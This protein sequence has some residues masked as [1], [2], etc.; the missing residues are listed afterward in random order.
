MDCRDCQSKIDQ[1]LTGMLSPDD[2][3]TF[4]EHINGCQNCREKVN[5]NKYVNDLIK[6]CDVT[7]PPIDVTKAVMDKITVLNL[8]RNREF[9][10]KRL[11]LSCRIS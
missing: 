4:N 7:V 9:V 5:S 6:K 11:L 10:V 8:K 2:L 3:D 1:Y